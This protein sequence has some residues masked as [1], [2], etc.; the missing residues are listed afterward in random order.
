MSD[1]EQEEWAIP[2]DQQPKP[3]DF[4]YDLFTRLNSVVALRSSI[5]EDGFTAHALGTERGGSG[6]LIDGSGL[7]LTIGYLVAEAEEIWLFGPDG[8]AIQGD[9][10]TY[11]FVTGFG[12]VQALGR[13]DL[14]PVPV[15][16]SSEVHVGDRV[17]FASAG[18]LEHAVDTQ[19]VSKR[20]F[21]GY[22]EYVLDEAFFSTPVHPSW[23]G[24]A[25][26]N[27]AGDLVGIGSLYVGDARGHGMASEGNMIV[28]I[29][30]VKP[31]LSQIRSGGGIQRSPRPW[32]GFYTAEADEHLF[33]AGLAP[34]GPAEKAGVQTGDLV[35]EVGGSPVGDLA[36]MFR[37]IW[38][39]GEAGVN[40]PL[41]VVRE[42]KPM[43]ITVSS[44]DRSDFLK[45]PRIH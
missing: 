25:V 43:S 16:K 4:A 9:V 41:T 1:D 6:V 36:D 10:L 11:D 18:G 33:V 24:A 31:L 15:G 22:W 14:E 37:T 44:A 40:V 27:K 19:I 28:P 35:L 30:L 39:L 34:N 12:L 13:F 3:T 5:P 42:G 2:L 38:S 17:V 20:E 7:I 23:G 26:L 45:S 21:A 29:D 8:S 32:L